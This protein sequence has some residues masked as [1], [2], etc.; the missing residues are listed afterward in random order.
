M[1]KCSSQSQTQSFP[2]FGPPHGSKPSKLVPIANALKKNKE[3]KG[4][5]Q[6]VKLRLLLQSNRE[7]KSENKQKQQKSANRS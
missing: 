4:I 2:P 6:Y 1:K 5:S 7:K 3:K